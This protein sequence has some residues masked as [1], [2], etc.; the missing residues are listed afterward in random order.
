M[1]IRSTLC[2]G[3]LVPLA[4]VASGSH[5]GARSAAVEAVASRDSSVTARLGSGGGNLELPGLAR[6]LVPAGALA[7]ETDVT[8][9]VTRA[10]AVEADW[11]ATAVLPNGAGPRLQ[12][13]TRVRLNGPIPGKPLR[14][15]MTV[16]PD[17]TASL[18]AGYEPL[19]FVYWISYGGEDILDGF[20]PVVGSYEPARGVVVVE[21]PRKAYHEAEHGSIEAMVVIGSVPGPSSGSGA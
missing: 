3:I 6:V 4:C 17:W 9:A 19:A 2:F 14:V 18:P 8:L 7:G 16:P 11:Q 1:T 15:T 21:I 20:D 13:E 12:R 10:P 5:G